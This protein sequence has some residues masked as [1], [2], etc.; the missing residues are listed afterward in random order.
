[1]L[2]YVDMKTK[3]TDQNNNND[4][5]VQFLLH[6]IRISDKKM[7]IKTKDGDMKQNTV[8]VTGAHEQLTLVESLILSHWMYIYYQVIL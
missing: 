8:T 1:M 4:E 6:C 7:A 3:P 2:R 5:H